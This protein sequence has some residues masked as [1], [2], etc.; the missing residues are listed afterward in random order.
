MP[1]VSSA[2]PDMTSAAASSHY[3]SKF[4]KKA[5]NAAFCIFELN[6]SGVC[7]VQLVGGLLVVITII[8]CSL[9]ISIVKSKFFLRDLY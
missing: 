9:N 8:V 4:E 2:T 7:L 5:E 6:Y 1:T 3:L